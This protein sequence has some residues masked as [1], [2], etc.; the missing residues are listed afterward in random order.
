MDRSVKTVD[1]EVTAME[2]G[3]FSWAFAYFHPRY[4]FRQKIFVALRIMQPVLYP[5]L[6]LVALPRK[7]PSKFP[8]NSSDG[9]PV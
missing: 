7:S 5:V 4:G 6:A 1:L 9:D 3:I 2:K 8:R